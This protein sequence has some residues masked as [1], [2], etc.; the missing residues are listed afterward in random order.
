[1]RWAVVCGAFL[2]LPLSLVGAVAHAAAV[3]GTFTTWLAGSE[4]PRRGEAVAARALAEMVALQVER[5]AVPMVGEARVVLQGWGRGQLGDDTQDD[6]AADLNL[7]YVETQNCVFSLRLGRQHVVSGVGRMLLLDGA[8]GRLQIG[9]GISLEAYGGAVVARRLRFRDAGTAL[10]ARVAKRFSWPG[11]IGLGYRRVA[12]QGDVRFHDLGVDAM[13][14]LDTWRLVAMAMVQP[15]AL[16][17]AD[18]RVEATW[19]AFE[20]LALNVHLE[21]TVPHLLL[22]QDSILTV[23]G[24]VA[25]DGAGM[26]GDWQ[27]SPYEAYTLN[28]LVLMIDGKLG[29]E[30]QAGW[31]TYRDAGHRSLVGVD[32]SRMAAEDMGYVQGRVLSSLAL[33]PLLRVGG[34]VRVYRY[35]EAINATTTSLLGSLNAVFDLARELKIVLAGSAGSTPLA[36]RFVRGTLRLAYGYGT[37]FV[38]EMA[39]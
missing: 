7:L 2:W 27:P 38:A 13:A 1:M 8:Q 16:A 34:D 26:G 30:V 22:P 23:F 37:E 15:E 10:G 19:S 20:A 36:T 11:E 6:T 4:E 25:R 5:L 21:R 3:R 17:L 9:H 29:Y 24:G 33:S 28:G 14:Y 12:R 39:P 18:A 31:R 32:A 35:D